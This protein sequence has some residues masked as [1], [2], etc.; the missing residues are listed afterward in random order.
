MSNKYIIDLRCDEGENSEVSISFYSPLIMISS[1]PLTSTELMVLNEFD[2]EYEVRITNQKYEDLVFK[3]SFLNQYLKSVCVNTG[4][5]QP[6]GI[7]V[8]NYSGVFFGTKARYKLSSLK[9]E[10]LASNISSA[11]KYSVCQYINFLDNISFY[12]E[13]F[14]AKDCFFDK[15]EVW[16][17]KDETYLDMLNIVELEQLQKFYNLNIFNSY[18]CTESL[19]KSKKLCLNDFH[20]LANK[21]KIDFKKTD[22]FP[23]AL[24]L[25]SVFYIKAAEFK[26][27]SGVLSSSFMFAF[28]ALEVYCDGLLVYYDMADIGDAKNKDKTFKRNT[29]LV[30]G[31]FVSGFGSKWNLIKDKPEF[32]NIE[33]SAVEFL[34]NVKE[35]RNNFVLTHGNVRVTSCI[36]R[37]AI[38]AVSNFIVKYEAEINQITTPWCDV[39][40]RVD[41][42]LL[43]DIVN[44]VGDF[45]LNKL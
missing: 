38:S 39:S 10:V 30:N 23:T 24:K 29:L 21:N 34:N 18:L 27:S 32:K 42:F 25:L 41:D 6:L 9:A 35:L 16:S 12:D 22:D 33:L 36:V 3:E 5:I 20:I 11:L 17:R 43:I 14:I 45:C 7:N 1:R 31:R 40:K 13:K 26:L 44:E 19:S 37:D 2:I 28:R 15:N 4:R 8:L